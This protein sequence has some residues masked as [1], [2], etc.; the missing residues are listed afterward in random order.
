MQVHMVGVCAHAHTHTHTC[1]I[2]GL[3]DMLPYDV[4]PRTSWRWKPFT[5]LQSSREAHRQ[6]QA[7]TAPPLDSAPMVLWAQ[8][9]ARAVLSILMLLDTFLNYL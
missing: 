2:R 6:K 9:G 4:S 5:H 3:S 8:L 1:V 7:A